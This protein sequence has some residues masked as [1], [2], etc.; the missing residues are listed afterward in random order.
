MDLIHDSMKE[1]SL[2]TNDLQQE[3][4]NSMHKLESSI[5]S[6]QTMKDKSMEVKDKM[7]ILGTSI[8]KVNELANSVKVLSCEINNISQNVLNGASKLSEN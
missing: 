7:L 3:L 6:T 1:T 5:E 4:V 8:D 2:K